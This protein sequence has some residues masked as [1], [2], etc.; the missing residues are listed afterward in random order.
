MPK[1]PDEATNQTATEK[2]PIL[3]A[4]DPIL[5]S[6]ENIKPLSEYDKL[7]LGKIKMYGGA[8]NAHSHLDRANTIDNKPFAH[9]GIDPIDASALSLKEKQNL[10]GELHKGI[11]YEHENLYTRIRKLIAMYIRLGYQEVVSFIDTTPDIELTAI[12]QALKVKEEF[13]DK[14]DFKVAS[15][16]IFG[17]KKPKIDPSRLE[18]FK[19]ASQKADIIG[20]LPEKDDKPTRIGYDGHVIE[21]LKIGIEEHKPVQ[22]HVDQENSP[23]ES[24]T[25]TIVQAVRWLGSP[26]IEGVSEP[27]VWCIHSISPSCYDEKRFTQLCENLKRYN[28]GIICCPTAAISM[29][30]LRPILTPTHNSIA[31]ILEFAKFEIPIM[32]GTDNICDVFVPN[33]D[34][35]IL[36]EIYMASNALRYYN[37][38]FW[39][40]LAT[41]QPLN[42][43]DRARIKKHLYEDNKVFDKLKQA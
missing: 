17:F 11:S 34:G 35:T 16:P 28:I 9:F 32:L 33:C 29:R 40:K 2:K 43:S 38:T 3:E 23:F 42:D 39:A 5:G 15:S 36:S 30:Q 10:T 22:F 13:K 24:G 26:I 6:A 19:A 18:L 8:I 1:T 20:A 14:I 4:D 31:R 41:G 7:I 27:T 37:T 25:E 21:A 12:D